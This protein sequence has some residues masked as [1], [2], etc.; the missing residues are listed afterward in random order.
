MFDWHLEIE[1]QVGEAER[2]T[3]THMHGSK[4]QNRSCDRP[5]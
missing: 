3:D 5:F 2:T 4:S 1:L